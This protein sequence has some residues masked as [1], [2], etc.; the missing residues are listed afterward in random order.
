M[1]SSPLPDDLAQDICRIAEAERDGRLVD[2]T[3]HGDEYGYSL[4]KLGR[5][6]YAIIVTEQANG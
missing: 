6:V 2:C 3:D 1:T 5:A 4:T